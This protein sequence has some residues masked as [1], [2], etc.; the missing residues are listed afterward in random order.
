[1][2]G[3]DQTFLTGLGFADLVALGFEHDAEKTADL[4]F[5]I[6]DERDHGFFGGRG[7]G[8]GRRV[9]FCFFASFGAF[10]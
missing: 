3:L 6:N 1:L 4:E 9:A 5:V 10:F 7:R 2:G 8:R